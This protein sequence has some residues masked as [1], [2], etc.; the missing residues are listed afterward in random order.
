MAVRAR[1][2]EQGLTFRAYCYNAGAENQYLRRLGLSAGLAGEIA[3]F[4]ASGEWVDLLRVWDA[5]L[6]TGR[7]SGL[8]TVAPLVGFHWQVDAPGGADSMVRYD[9]AAA[10]DDGARQ[11]LLNYNRGDVQATLALR[12]WMASARVPGVEDL[13]PPPSR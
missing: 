5:Q 10:G 2:R 12:E 13:E 1:A 3:D 7:G 8:K 11:W 9:A 4:I 6:I